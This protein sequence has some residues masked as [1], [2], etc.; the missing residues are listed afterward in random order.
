M[1]NK[2]VII[3]VPWGR[4][5]REWYGNGSVVKSRHEQRGT[6]Q[7]PSWP[8]SN[9]H[10]RVT[11]ELRVSTDRNQPP[12]VPDHRTRFVVTH[13][14]TGRCIDYAV[15]PSRAAA[16]RAADKYLA[17][18]DWDFTDVDKDRYVLER[19]RFAKAA[20]A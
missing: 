17:H 5:V 2:P 9:P 16:R 20:A 19:R 10:L 12:Y 11:P 7:V 6:V 18:L 8:T 3:N 14:P 13:K 15:F 1:S 4:K